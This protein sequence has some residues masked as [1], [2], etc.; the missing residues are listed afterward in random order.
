MKKPIKRNQSEQ[1]IRQYAARLEH[2]RV[3]GKHNVPK[4]RKLK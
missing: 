4:L 2:C 1:R 3:G